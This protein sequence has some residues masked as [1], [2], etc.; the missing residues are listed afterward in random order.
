MDADKCFVLSQ[1][2]VKDENTEFNPIPI[3]ICDAIKEDRLHGNV[4]LAGFGVGLS[5]G[6]T[7]LKCL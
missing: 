1:G 6:A 4:L 7:I 2:V 3:A 5:W